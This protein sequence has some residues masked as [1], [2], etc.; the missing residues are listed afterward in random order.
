VLEPRHG[1][2]LARPTLI[3]LAFADREHKEAGPA[4]VEVLDIVESHLA[5]DQRWIASGA[6]PQTGR[7]PC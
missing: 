3:G 1:D 4:E 7:R 2:E 5:D 6:N